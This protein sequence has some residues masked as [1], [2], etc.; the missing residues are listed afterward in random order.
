MVIPA[1]VGGAAWAPFLVAFATRLTGSRAD[2]VTNEA[3]DLL[4]L[5]TVPV[6]DDAV[7]TGTEEVVSVAF[8]VVWDEDNTH[9][10]VLMGKEGLVTVTKVQTP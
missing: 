1:E 2:V 8:F 7:L 4:E 9:D 6:L 5:V 3:L 10:T